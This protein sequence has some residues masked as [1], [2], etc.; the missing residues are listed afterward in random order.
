META[1]CTAEDRVRTAI[2]C[3]FTIVYNT[4][5]IVGET[6][7]LIENCSMGLEFC[8][9]C[10]PPKPTYNC[11]NQLSVS[12]N[13]SDYRNPTLKNPFYGLKGKI[14]CVLLNLGEPTGS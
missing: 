8:S 9:P 12:L 14:D 10:D 6:K 2:D 5:S 13:A 11:P 3:S 7:R 1:H 4:A